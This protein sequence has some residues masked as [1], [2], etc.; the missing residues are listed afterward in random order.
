MRTPRQIVDQEVL[1]SLSSLI[2]TLAAGAYVETEGW[3][4]HDHGARAA[5]HNLFAQAAEI[6]APVDD[7]E[8]AAI[9]AG[10]TIEGNYFVSPD[11]P[12]IRHDNAQRACEQNGIEPYQREV[13][14]HWAVSTWLAEKLAEQG[15]QVDTDFADLCVWA[16][17]TT[18]QAIYADS[19]I[20]AIARQYCDWEG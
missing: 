7:W 16:R 2:S 20:E 17:T 4:N 1:C 12:T 5:I 8:E 9:Q 3:L 13:Y 14:E 18:G 15:E 6:S 10:W 19:V 11:D